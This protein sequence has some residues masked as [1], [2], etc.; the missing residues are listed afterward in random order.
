MVI[1]VKLEVTDNNF[2]VIFNFT[3]Y[4]NTSI[5]NFV[6]YGKTRLLPAF[7]NWQ[8]FFCFHRW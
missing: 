4:K 8:L 6:Y 1:L 3:Q 5:G 7:E 2:W